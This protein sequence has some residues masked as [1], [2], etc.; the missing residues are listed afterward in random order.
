[1]N[2]LYLLCV[3]GCMQ[4]LHT[5]NHVLIWMK[6]LT[7]L[8][9]NHIL[10]WLKKLTL[11]KLV[12]LASSVVGLVCYGLSSSFKHLFGKRSSWNMLLFIVFS[13]IIFFAVLFAPERSS[14]ASFRLE[15]HLAFLVLIITSVY[16][17][18]VDK[19]VKGTPD[20]YSLISYAAFA[21]MSVGLSNLTQF[22]FQIDLLYFFCGSLI[23]QLM[24]IKLW[25]VVVG[26]AFTYALI[27]LRHCP[28]RRDTRVETLHVGFYNPV[29]LPV[30]DLGTVSNSNQS[31][32]IFQ[33]ANVGVDNTQSN[34]H[35][36]NEARTSFSYEGS[37]AAF[38]NYFSHT[39][40]TTDR[41]SSSFTFIYQ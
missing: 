5:L 37:P 39:V 14:S 8:M 36:Q 21:T 19:L 31:I 13:F 22:G 32:N 34:S 1:M 4:I 15:A 16:S 27:K 33:Q 11:E 18:F 28:Y 38:N 35:P 29:F 24:K 17:F 23:I 20:V 7:L 26:G 25:L 9:L 41:N 6:K 40:G 30:D 12:C 3:D 10:I 2:A